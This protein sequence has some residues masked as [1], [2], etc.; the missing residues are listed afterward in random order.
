MGGEFGDLSLSRPTFG[1]KSSPRFGG[2]S[3]LGARSLDGG[4]GGDG[5][6]FDYEEEWTNHT[7][8]LTLGLTDGGDHE[9]HEEEDL[10]VSRRVV[11]GV[12][13]WSEIRAR[14]KHATLERV[15]CDYYE[16]ATSFF[17]RAPVYL[18]FETLSQC[19]MDIGCDMRVNFEEMCLEVR[20]C[21]VFGVV[22]GM[23]F[24]RT[25]LPGIFCTSAVSHLLVCRLFI[26]RSHRS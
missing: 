16:K 8:G 2:V 12:G 5:D 17:S 26:S 9:G 18:V 10:L 4:D 20:Y 19:L 3:S 23:L 15:F 6:G 24:L 21:I 14:L 25:V 7:V 11:S 13:G 1:D 22:L